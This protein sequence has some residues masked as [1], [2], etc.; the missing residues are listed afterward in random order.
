MLKTFIWIG[1]FLTVGQFVAA[2]GFG[3]FAVPVAVVVVGGCFVI[4]KIF[5]R[6]SG[7]GSQSLGQV[8]K[9]KEPSAPVILSF[10]VVFL[11]LLPL[12]IELLMNLLGISIAKP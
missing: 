6:L 3:F 7:T 12:V 4:Y 8:S 1:I 11:I 5:Q 10:F 9:R 2:L